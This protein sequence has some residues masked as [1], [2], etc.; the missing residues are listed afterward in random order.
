MR[1]VL[2]TPIYLPEIG[3]PATYIKEICER[4]G[5]EH[6][7]VVVAYARNGVPYGGARLVQISK[8]APLPVRLFKFFIATLREAR[9]AD[10]IYAQ[11]AVA[12][13]LPAVVAGMIMRKPVVIKFVGDEAWE[14]AT[15]HRT[16]SKQLEAF[17]KTQDGTLRTKL[18]MKLQGWV[19]RRASRVT[20]PSAYLR[21][22]IV[23]T[24]GI[25]G[26]RAVTNYNA[27]DDHG[28]PMFPPTRV[29]HQM[30][31]T[32]RLT[33]WKG[34]D[35]AIR[36]LPY[37]RERF[38]DAA[39]TIAGDGPEREHLEALTRELGLTSSVRFLGNVS[40]T[41]TW[42]LRKESDVYIL[43]STYEGLPH[44]V[45]TSFAAG[46]PLVATN[47]S[48]T[49]EAVVDGVNGLL[50]PPQDSHALAHAVLRMFDDAP[51]RER[52]IAGGHATLREK[53]SWATHLRELTS[54]LSLP[55]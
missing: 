23:E 20:T 14:R 45:L 10:V 39:L 42:Q 9:H 27:A 53:F 44:T 6:S 37:I 29:P 17:L 33:A 19:L 11:N 43:N 7:L 1:I 30:V 47:I 48:G 32:A 2:A 28:T 12:A 26:E 50:I 5:D 55:R 21:D 24:Y 31:M 46:I 52:L 15:Q 51:L 34:V 13:G 18:M 40:R 16:T 35:G 25:K 54:L 49:N 8:D 38:Q 3:G 41:E 4:M 36:A 22:V